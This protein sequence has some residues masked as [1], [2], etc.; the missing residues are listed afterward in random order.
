[1]VNP[2]GVEWAESSAAPTFGKVMKFLLEY[3]K[4]KPTE[5]PKTSPNASSQPIVVAQPAPVPAIEDNKKSKK[6]STSKDI[7][8]AIESGD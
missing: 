5:D 6:E 1:I 4:V 3:H 7:A 2:K 8:K